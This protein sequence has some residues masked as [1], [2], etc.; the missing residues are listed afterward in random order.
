MQNE[1]SVNITPEEH[2]TTAKYSEEDK[3]RKEC[4]RK[5]DVKR[6][7]DLQNEASHYRGEASK[8]KLTLFAE[9]A[10]RR[11]EKKEIYNTPLLSVAAYVGKMV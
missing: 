2:R 6:V 11:V 5:A 3:L 4:W 7:C 9:Q 8:D 1:I 10:L